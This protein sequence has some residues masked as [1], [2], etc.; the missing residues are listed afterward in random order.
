M[1]ITFDVGAF[2]ILQY[3]FSVSGGNR[4]IPGTGNDASNGASSDPFTGAGR[5]VPKYN[6]Q[7]KV[8][9]GAR[10]PFTGKV[11]FRIPI[12]IP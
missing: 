1:S 6:N 8:S 5:Y 9:N 10:D 3:C 12:T 2:E 7:P 4:Y 11:P